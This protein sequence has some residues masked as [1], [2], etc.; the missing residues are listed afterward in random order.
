[1]D[2]CI[3]GANVVLCGA[4]Y[5][6]D[7]GDTR[8]SGSEVMVRKL[9]QMGMHVRVHDPYVEHW[10]EFISQDS[11]P[12]PGQSKARFFRQPRKA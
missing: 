2:R 5:R 9:T 11:Y 7:V 6:Q 3:A 12:T 8:Y 10:Y 4:S 1:M